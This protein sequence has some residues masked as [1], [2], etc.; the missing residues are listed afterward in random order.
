MAAAIQLVPTH[1]LDGDMEPF[2]VDVV[3]RH[4]AHHLDAPVG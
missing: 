1:T 2:V 4:A 3:V